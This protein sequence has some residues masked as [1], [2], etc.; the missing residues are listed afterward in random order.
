MVEYVFKNSYKEKPVTVVLKP[1]SVHVLKAGS[2]IKI[3]YV[4]VTAVRLFRKSGNLFQAVL[5]IEDRDP[6]VITNRFHISEA[7]FEARNGPYATF[8]RELHRNLKEKSDAVFLSGI[9]YN[10]LVIR[11]L[12]GCF[13]AALIAFIAEFLGSAPVNSLL[14]ALGISVVVVVIML[15]YKRRD[16]AKQY[17]PADI[18][19]RFLP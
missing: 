5:D 16:I 13:S 4:Q 18:P 11:F 7:D 8:I 12:M 19:M 10:S 14:L 2:E 3:P 6:L 1:F 15:V 9:S 17:N